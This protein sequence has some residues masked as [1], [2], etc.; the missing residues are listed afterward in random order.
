MA[1]KYSERIE[2]MDGEAR[3]ELDSRIREYEEKHGWQKT[4]AKYKPSPLQLRAIKAGKDP[5]KVK[6]KST[7]KAAKKAGKKKAKKAAKKSAKKTAKKAAKKPAKKKKKA[8]ASKKKVARVP[9]ANGVK[10]NAKGDLI[11]EGTIPASE[12]VQ[13][14]LRHS[15]RLAKA[16]RS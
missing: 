9:K 14:I 10:T 3:A 8:K 5:T 13:M 4:L 2:N 7:K 1:R 11:I 12:F 6:A 15:E 16:A